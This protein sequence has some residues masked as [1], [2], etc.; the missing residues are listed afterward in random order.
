MNYIKEYDKEAKAYWYQKSSYHTIQKDKKQGMLQQNSQKTVNDIE[1]LS[2]Y[3]SII[4]SKVNK[5]N[6]PI[7]RQNDWMN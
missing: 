7:K 2:P 4:T 6:F 3:L 1:I 5:L